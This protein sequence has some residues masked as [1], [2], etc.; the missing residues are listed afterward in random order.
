MNE[1]QLQ[2][3]DAIVE[4]VHGQVDGQGETAEDTGSLNQD[5]DT[6]EGN[7]GGPSWDTN[8]KPGIDQVLNDVVEQ[9]GDGH[10]DVIRGLQ[11]QFSQNGEVEARLR[12]L[13]S[14]IEEVERLKAGLE[15]GTEVEIDEDLEGVSPEQRE[16]LR[17]VLKADGFVSQADLDEQGRSDMMEESNLEGTELFGDSFGELGE[18]GEFLLNEEAKDAMAPVYDRVKVQDA[19]TFKDLHILT[20]FNQLIESAYKQGSDSTLERLRTENGA[21]VNTLQRANGVARRNSGGPTS[22]QIYDPEAVKDMSVKNKLDTVMGNAF[23]ALS[24]SR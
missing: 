13:N 6:T 2:V 10:A 12:Q 21:K 19:L 16:L 7:A 22:A 18:N 20:N 17:K 4:T 11:K 9:L 24:S 8:R 1:I 3:P 14:S 23:K 5:Q 15:S